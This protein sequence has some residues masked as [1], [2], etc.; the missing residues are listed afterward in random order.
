MDADIEVKQGDVVLTSGLGGSYTKGLLIG[1]VVRVEGNAKDGT[2]TIIVA[3]NEQAAV[4]EEVIVVFSASE[5]TSFV[6]SPQSNQGSAGNSD[7]SGEANSA[8]SGEYNPPEGA[9]NE[10]DDS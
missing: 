1:T 9:Q 8:T 2:R 5:S 10:E 4:L 6:S 3:P 7:D